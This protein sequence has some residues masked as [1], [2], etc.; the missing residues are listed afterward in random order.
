MPRSRYQNCFY[1]FRGPS[2]KEKAA[3]ADKQLEDNTTKALINVLEHSDRSIT[4][5]FLAALVCHDP[6][7]VSEVE[8]FLQR[9]PDSPAAAKLL[10]GISNRGEI[11]PS[12][13]MSAGGGSRIDGAIHVAGAVTVLIETKVVDALDGSQLHRHASD[14][15]M[16]GKVADGNGWK[17]PPEWK[18]QSWVTVYEWAQR[19]IDTTEREP[20][21]FLLRQLVEYLELAGLAPT[22][23]LRP[24]HFDFLSQPAEERDA[25]I[26]GEIR[27]RLGSIWS[28]VESELGPARF[29]T[30]L[31]EVRVGNLREGGDHAWA[32][33]N[34]DSSF[35]LPNLTIEMYPNELTLCIVGGFDRQAGCVERWLLTGDR[36]GLD[37][38]FE[39]AVFRRTARGGQD[40]KKIVWQGA[41]WAPVDDAYR[42]PLDELTPM[43][44]QTRLAEWRKA[45]DPKRQRIGFHIRKAWNR[46]EILDRKDLPAI[47]AEIIEGLLPVLEAIRKA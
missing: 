36:S 18:I 4:R 10:L 20:D 25:A 2:S 29:R 19:E 16:P 26:A 17:P 41:T 1:Y 23:A 9:R 32:Q 31:G 7:P 43:A 46:E 38:G 3:E 33:S 39:L 8:Y 45:L 15:G 13:W 6:G 28:K 5:R 44:L 42:F 27:R 40:G 12:S 37:A 30:V 34:A 47:L 21:K 22:W 14:C 35:D 11:D 24:E